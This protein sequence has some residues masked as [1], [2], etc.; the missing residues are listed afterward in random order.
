MKQLTIAIACLGFCFS[1]QSNKN[2]STETDSLAVD[3]VFS[4]QTVD[5]AVVA[6]PT[7]EEIIAA[8][9]QNEVPLDPQDFDYT[10][11]GLIN[12]QIKVMVNIFKF[13]GEQKARAVYLSTKKIINMDAVYPAVGTFEL[14]EKVDGKA[15][16]LWKIAV[17]EED[18]FTGTWNS[19]DG[20]KQM[21]ITLT[22]SGSEVDE[23]LPK[24]EIKTGFYFLEER[25][26]D[27]ASKEEFPLLYK[28][29]LYVKN[30]AANTLYFDLYIQG[31]PPGVHVGMV[32]GY[33][34]KSGNAYVY[35]NEE[36]CEITMIFSGGKVSLSQ[37]GS[38]VNCEFGQGI[39]AFGTLEKKKE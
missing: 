39:G 3:S 25:N 19:P 28:E 15:T 20:K 1:C 30:M 36:G 7:E 14:T 35:T 22:M 12:N 24:E 11:E 6:G 18:I 5:T 33:A 2:N 17:A 32:N 23:V 29:E 31:S 13:R 4:S 9:D 27:A 10:Y 8:E 21:P 37:K 34:S 16:G 38:D 26:E